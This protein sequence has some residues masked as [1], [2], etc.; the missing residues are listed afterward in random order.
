M[1]K[2]ILASFLSAAM[3]LTMF[4]AM[5]VNAQDFPVPVTAN[6]V[7]PSPS[8]IMTIPEKINFGTQAQVL[9]KYRSQAKDQFGKDVLVSAPIEVTATGISNL[10][11]DLGSK[12]QLDITATFDKTLSGKSAT[13]KT[14]GYVVKQGNA[15]IQSGAVIGSFYNDI[16]LAGKGLTENKLTAN[17]TINRADIQNADAYTGTMTFTISQPT[18]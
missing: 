15:E 9:E 7:I 2:K 14:I 11:D 13:G 17:A 18:K 12:A 8:F 5:L 10:F 16:D 1:K 3:I 4:S 6:A